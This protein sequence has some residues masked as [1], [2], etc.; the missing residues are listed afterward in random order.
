MWVKL[1]KLAHCCWTSL[2]LFGMCSTASSSF[3]PLY[4][5]QVK[6]TMKPLTILCFMVEQ[7]SLLITVF[8]VSLFNLLCQGIYNI[9][10][11]IFMCEPLMHQMKLNPF[12]RGWLH[13]HI[14]FHHCICKINGFGGNGIQHYFLR[15][16]IPESNWGMTLTLGFDKFADR[17]GIISKNR[18][19]F[20]ANSSFTGKEPEVSLGLYFYI[21]AWNKRLT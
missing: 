6:S 14:V 4:I 18:E 15:N 9:I 3:F 7:L 8:R 12:S 1:G 21:L 5:S 16:I 13:L 20:N 11:R 17:F 19:H 10:N 2:N